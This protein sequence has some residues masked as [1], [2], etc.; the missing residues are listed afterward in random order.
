MT[1]PVQGTWVDWAYPCGQS[2][3]GFVVAKVHEREVWV[4]YHR[5]CDV[6]LADWKGDFTILYLAQSLAPVSYGID[7]N[8]CQCANQMETE[9]EFL[10]HDSLV[11]IKPLAVSVVGR[12]NWTW[13][14]RPGLKSYVARAIARDAHFYSSWTSGC[15]QWRPDTT[16]STEATKWILFGEIYLNLVLLQLTSIRWNPFMSKADKTTFY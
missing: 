11:K 3:T 4:S 5:A 14:A 16:K 1:P 15:G 9:S 2:G 13:L 12:A 10:T 7:A 6:W 8:D